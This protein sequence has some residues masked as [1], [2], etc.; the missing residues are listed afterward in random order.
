MKKPRNPRSMFLCKTT[1]PFQEIQ[2]FRRKIQFVHKK[3]NFYAEQFYF[4]PKSFNKFSSFIEIAVETTGKNVV[5]VT[6][7]DPR[8]P[9]GL[10]EKTH[11]KPRSWE[12]T[13][14]LATLPTTHQ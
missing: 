11:K 8:K 3:I 2:I 10:H 9:Q 7:K 4:P 6:L 14:E 1:F 5:S 12:K 13:Q